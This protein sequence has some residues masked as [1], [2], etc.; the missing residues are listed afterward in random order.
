M[1]FGMFRSHY[2]PILADFGSS[3]VKLMQSTTGEFPT[4]AAAAFIP[5][6]DDMRSRPVEERF[7]LLAREMPEL[8]SADRLFDRLRVYSVAYDVRDLL[9]NPPECPV[10]DLDHLH[11]YHRLTGTLEGQS[12]L[13]RI[14]TTKDL[15]A[16]D[17]KALAAA[18][19]DFKKNGAY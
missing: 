7:E 9:E 10:E 15:N 5:F 14:E 2:S 1:R 6:S 4:V 3:G 17:E 12:H 18:I 8:F 13:D 11:P 16:D 19:E